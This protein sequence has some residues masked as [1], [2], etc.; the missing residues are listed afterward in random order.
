MTTRKQIIAP[1]ALT[2]IQ[3]INKAIRESGVPQELVEFAG[4]RAS[5][6]NGCSACVYGHT[7]NLR[8]A[9]VGDEKIDTVAVWRESP[10]FS[11]TERAILRLAERVSRLADR[12]EE[13]VPDELWDELNDHLDDKSVATVVLAIALTNFF[14]RL[15]TT[16]RTPAGTTW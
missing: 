10:Y 7:A 6:I 12:S 4:L 2:G 11:D 13:S 3:H 14:N 8:K 9:G 5:Q 1:D 15:N 16:Y